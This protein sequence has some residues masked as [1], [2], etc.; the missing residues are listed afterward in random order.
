MKQLAVIRV[1]YPQI[2]ATSDNR[3]YV[4]REQEGG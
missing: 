1:M 3:Y 2:I 4:N